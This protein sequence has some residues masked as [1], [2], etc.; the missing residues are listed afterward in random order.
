MQALGLIET[1][2]LIVAVESADAMLKAADVTLLEKTY[3]GGGLVSITVTGEVAAVTAAVD[4][5]VAAARLINRELLISQHV[6]PRPHEELSGLV[7]STKPRVKVK[8]QTN[9]SMK[10][11]P[12]AK[13]NVE[14]AEVEEKRTI[15]LEMDLD[16]MN[17]NTLDLIVLESGLDEA[18]E[19]LNNLKVTKLRNLA[20]EYKEIG[21]AGRKISKADKK[22]LLA[23]LKKYYTITK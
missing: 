2:G 12:D 22:T 11:E 20:R 6:I 16:V 4:A 3:V 17:K 7:V 21:I 1:R 15:S 9:E 8:L 18:F 13:A 14:K 5:G 19:V 23:E 10:I